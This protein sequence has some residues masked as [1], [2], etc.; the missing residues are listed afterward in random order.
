MNTK[1][2]NIISIFAFFLLFVS[3]EDQLDIAKKGNLGGEEEFYKTDSDAEQAEAAALER[4]IS[5]NLYGLYEGEYENILKPVV[6]FCKII[7]L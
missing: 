5:S 3:C 2:I 6:E 4:V 1:L 7:K